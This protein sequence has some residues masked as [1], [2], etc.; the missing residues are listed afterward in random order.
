MSQ[1]EFAMIRHRLGKK[2]RSHLEDAAG[3]A[4]SRGD[5]S[6]NIE[7]LLLRMLSITS[8]DF[9]AI[10]ESFEANPEQMQADLETRLSNLNS[11]PGTSPVLG[12]LL[13]TVFV[14][15]WLFA[16]LKNNADRL[17]SGDIITALVANPERY[18][19]IT[20]ISGQF[21]RIDADRLR[22]SFDEIVGNSGEVTGEIARKVAP[23]GGEDSSIAQFTID[24][25]QRAKEG[26][27]D[28]AVGR[29]NEIRLVA[30]V[31]TRRRQNNP[32]LVGEPGVGKTAVAEGFAMKVAAGDVPPSLK[33]VAIHSL[34]LTLLQAGASMRGE[35]EARLVGLIEEVKS[36]PQPIILFIDEAH[37][38]VGAG[39]QA[40]QGDAA[41]ILKPALARGELR[42][43]A[44][45]TW[46]EYKQYF[47]TDAAL[48]RRFQVVKVDEP[49][50]ETAH[51]MLR[52]VAPKLEAHHTVHVL[53][54]AIRESI[55]MTARYLPGRQLPDK[56]VSVLDTA[57]ARVC[58]SQS[59][60]P[61]SVELARG[62][63]SMLMTEQKALLEESRMGRN[64]TDRLAQLDD[65]VNQANDRA[66]QFEAQWSAEL[67]LLERIRVGR[68]SARAGVEIVGVSDSAIDAVFPGDIQGSDE[69]Q[70]PNVETQSGVASLEAEL[71]AVQ[72]ENPLVLPLVDATTVAEVVASLTG[73]PVGK[74]ADSEIA[75]I[76]DLESALKQRVIGQDHAL[77][78]ISTAIRQSRVRLGDPRKP[79]GVFLLVGT[80]GVGKTETA[81]AIAESLFGREDA[82]TVINMSE[83]KQS[84]QA[85]SLVG[86]PPGY[87]GYGRGGVLTEAVRRRPY[88]VLLLDEIEK[89]HDSIQDIFYNLFDK[90]NLSDSEGRNVD[91]RN[92]LVLMTSNAGTETINRLCPVGGERPDE[93]ELASALRPELLEHFRPAF[94]G[95]CSIVPYYPIGAEIVSTLVGINF[96]RIRRRLLEGY[97]ATLEYDDAL[98]AHYADNLLDRDTGAR[99]IESKLSQSVVAPL[100]DRLLDCL[101]ED[102]K[103]GKVHMKLGDTGELLIGIVGK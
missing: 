36:S 27:L 88:G 2:L 7:H 40:G 76:R 95:R 3:L 67:S 94:L 83:F 38:L 57:C 24:L 5:E 10:L 100:S 6:V 89:A 47:E 25:T 13:M 91:F 71:K 101:A 66:S 17:R 96:Q 42:T 90:G 102:K 52:G 20:S 68:E 44:A 46:S 84:H 29:A 14:D 80:S 82:A 51:R 49:T 99:H 64:H 21:S 65:L 35:F 9:R 32:I 15:A 8:G 87:V 30:D 79:V 86:A 11:T 39:G 72:G 50:E 60:T 12:S 16:S 31:L 43:I 81:M 62:E 56:A 77:S 53:D 85:A 92:T 75:S 41:N 18:Q 48:T 22:A 19:Q 23:A 26:E 61:S 55:R 4:V 93:A 34:D 58:L 73:V 1:N 69:N 28:E 103:V 78:S 54:E 74:M 98:I 70:A 33:N 97:G 45:T 37:S 59:A 63:L